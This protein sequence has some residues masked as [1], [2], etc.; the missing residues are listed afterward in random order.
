MSVFGPMGMAI[1]TD[2]AN[3]SPHRAL[4]CAAGKKPAPELGFGRGISP[5]SHLLPANNHHAEEIQ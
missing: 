3:L 1:G 2:S 4:L 5:G